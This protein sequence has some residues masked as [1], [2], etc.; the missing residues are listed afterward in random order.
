VTTR[1]EHLVAQ[2]PI[3]LGGVGVLGDEDVDAERALGQLPGARDQP[4]N[5]VA[6]LAV[7][8]EDAEATRVRDRSGQFRAGPIPIPTE[9]IGTGPEQSTQW[10]LQ[11]A[12]QA[13]VPRSTAPGTPRLAAEACGGSERPG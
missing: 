5:P 11:S 1:L 8:A 2:R 3:L 4:P 7:G 13:I 6:G 10:R 9:Q 12:H